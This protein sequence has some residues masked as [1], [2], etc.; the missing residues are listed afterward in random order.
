MTHKGLNSFSFAKFS[1][2]AITV[3]SL[4]S[5]LVTIFL[6]GSNVSVTSGQV[7][8]SPR[9][10]ATLTCVAG[11]TSSQFVISGGGVYI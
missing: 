6:S 7:N 3:R 1:F 8:L 11:G 2:E 4:P 10:L 5:D 9:G